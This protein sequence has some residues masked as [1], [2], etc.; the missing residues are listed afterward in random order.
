MI[1][2]LI[3]SKRFSLS[4]FFFV[5]AIFCFSLTIFRQYRTQE[6]MYIFLNWNLF[7]AFIPW[8]I[9]SLLIIYPKMQKK[10]LLIFIFPLWLLFFPNTVY[11]LT[12]IIHLRHTHYGLFW[13]D[14]FLVLTFALTGLLLGLISLLD[15]EKML[16]KYFNAK[17]TTL[18]IVAIIFISSFGVYLGRFLRWNSWDII[19][20]PFTLL[21]DIAHNI[22]FPFKHTKTWMVTILLGILL[23][24]IF[25]TIKFI[26]Y[27]SKNDFTSSN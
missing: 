1:K 17:F 2:K 6:N 15:V 19:N 25:W 12:D 26:R 21:Y 23:N 14:L 3:Q 10:I 13:Y 9:S 27:E 7:L 16:L 4:I 5:V 24:I 22:I 20:Q 18:I 11:I 8:G